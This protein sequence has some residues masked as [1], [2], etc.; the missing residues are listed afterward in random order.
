MRFDLT[1]NEFVREVWAGKE[2][3]VYGEQFWRP[4]CH[5]RDLAEAC[6]LALECESGKIRQNVYNV[7]DS[8][9]NYQK[10]F[11][12]EEIQRLI[13]DARVRYV[14]KKEDPR[15]YKV[16]FNKI[17]NELDFRITRTV[18]EGIREVLS[19]LRDGIFTDPYQPKYQNI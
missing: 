19:A 1:V 3:Q 16:D 2:L 15:D 13:P 14:H 12:A 17:R 8:R 5:V 10:K 11:L 9:E 6:L 18:P 4:Y 7:G